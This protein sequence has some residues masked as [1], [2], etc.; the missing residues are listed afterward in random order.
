[1]ASRVLTITIGNEVTRICDA[2]YSA[3]KTIMV[4]SAITIP[5]PAGAVED[6][7]IIDVG[8]MAKAL[9][10]ALDENRIVTKDVIFTIQSTK[11]ANKEVL[12]PDL[13]EP[14]LGN[15]IKTNATD[16]FPVNIDEY[17]MTYA[18][19]EYVAD[20][21]VKKI[22]M[23]MA[24]APEDMIE[25]YYQIASMLSMHIE[26]VD[27]AANSTLQLLKDQIDEKPSIVIQVG[28]TSTGVTILNHGVLQLMR[29]VPYGRN[30]VASAFMEK[31]GITMDEAIRALTDPRNALKE[32]FDEGDYLTDSLRYL[33]GNIG[34][35][36][37]YYTGKNPEFPIEK[38]YVIV[39]GNALH[40][41]GKLFSNELNMKVDKIE[42][43]KHVAPAQG[44][45]VDMREMTAFVPNIGSMLKPVNFRPNS[46]IQKEKSAESGKRFR[47]M[48]LVAVLVSLL[49]LTIPLVGMFAKMSTRNDLQREV[50]S[51]K[52]IYDIVDQYYDSKDRFSDV[53][54]FAVNAYNND[55]YFMN[56]MRYLETDMPSDISISSMSVSNGAV[57]MSFSAGSKE[58]VAAFIT[59]LKSKPNIAG[60]SVPSL[61]ESVD[62]M[63]VTTVSGSLSCTFTAPAEELINSI[64]GNANGAEGETQANP[65]DGTPTE[66]TA[67]SE[68]AAEGETSGNGETPAETGTGAEGATDVATEAETMTKEAE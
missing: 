18:P 60:V 31:R 53:A 23:M 47:T 20:E 30:T 45:G 19:I 64:I 24:V 67:Q 49:L 34:R 50:D 8:I 11:I 25:P 63:G 14:K 3:Q 51:M 48:L 40:G 57:T 15:Y 7:I 6:G 21:N 33:V 17:V 38:A 68:T 62:E 12:V 4:Y 41:V 26:A 61:S 29:T 32:T 10:D 9:Q 36:M 13:K 55:D 16:Y 1:M 66:T 58:T 5:T 42:T 46:V 59:I 44:F 39:E 54:N 35:I 56:F 2:A 43:L 52:Y 27:Y 28:D 37:D 65:V 22:K